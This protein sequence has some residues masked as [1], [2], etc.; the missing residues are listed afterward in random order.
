MICNKGIKNNMLI[1]IN[2]RKK[3]LSEEHLFKSHLTSILFE[4]H[5]KIN[6]GQKISFV[7]FYNEL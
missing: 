4:K 1:L 5:N 7:N 3:L 2:F 6:P